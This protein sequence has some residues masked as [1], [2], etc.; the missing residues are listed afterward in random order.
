[1]K[2][3]WERGGNPWKIST[4]IMDEGP[5]RQGQSVSASFTLA[6]NSLPPAVA[7]FFHSHSFNQQIIIK[8][9][10]VLDTG[11]RVQSTAEDSIENHR[12]PR[13]AHILAG[14]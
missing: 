10:C 7:K 8:L 5:W 2:E 14:S 4:R 9:Y 1:M 13:G 6:V 12:H 11:P 3:T